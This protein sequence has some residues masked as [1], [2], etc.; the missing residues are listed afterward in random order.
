VGHW[1]AY[2]SKNVAAILPSEANV[3]MV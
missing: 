2:D 1:R 3:L